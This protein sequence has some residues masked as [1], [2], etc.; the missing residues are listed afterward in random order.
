MNPPPMP[1]VFQGPGVGLRVGAP[2]GTRLGLPAGPRQNSI[3]LSRFFNNDVH[4]A[5]GTLPVEVTAPTPTTPVKPPNS[6]LREFNDLVQRLPPENHDLLQTIVE[7]LARATVHAKTTKMP[8]S[9]LLLVFCPSV[10]I[11][12]SVFKI[13]VENH[14]PIFDQA[15]LPPPSPSPS[16]HPSEGS[17]V[18]EGEGINAAN[19]TSQPTPSTETDYRHPRTPPPQLPRKEP[20]GLQLDLKPPPLPLVQATEVPNGAASPP[21]SAYLH[22]PGLGLEPNAG[23]MSPSPQPPQLVS[24]PLGPQTTSHAT[25]PSMSPSSTP[26]S[27]SPSLTSE[28]NATVPNPGLQ[29]FSSDPQPPKPIPV[30]YALQPAASQSSLHSHS[31]TVSIPSV[32]PSPSVTLPPAQQDL[33]APSQDL[34]DGPSAF[35]THQVQLKAS[36]DKPLPNPDSPVAPVA[37]EA[38]SPVSSPSPSVPSPTLED[39]Q[40]SGD[41]ADS[42]AKP[43]RRQYPRVVSMAP[44]LPEFE[45]LPPMTAS[46][47][48][49]IPSLSPP[50]P[51]PS[52]APLFALAPPNMNSKSM[53]TSTITPLKVKGRGSE[54][55]KLVS[56]RTGTSSSTS[57][58]LESSISRQ[59]PP[60]IS[61][62]DKEPVSVKGDALD[63]DMLEVSETLPLGSQLT[64]LM[65]A[66]EEDMVHVDDIQEKTSGTEPSGLPEQSRP[67]SAEPPKRID[68][69]PLETSPPVAESSTTRLDTFVFG[70]ST[71]TSPEAPIIAAALPTAPVFVPPIVDPVPEDIAMPKDEIG[72][73]SKVECESLPI[74]ELIS[75][76]MAEART[77]DHT[78]LQNHTPPQN[79]SINEVV[80]TVERQSASPSPLIDALPQREGALDTV[81]LAESQVVAPPRLAPPGEGR[82]SDDWAA[83]VL[84]AATTSP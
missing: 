29:D 34:S 64:P 25:P 62:S 61:P 50:P 67:S 52:L 38:P 68:S 3:A 35:S 70:P 27:S 46:F 54:P 28:L 18:Y 24:N 84:M 11:N 51:M 65:R 57:S 19:A 55:A 17:D 12:S 20:A 41:D 71:H 1:T 77:Q 39:D 69:L 2:L 9:N 13:M 5:P 60:G 14:E 37:P 74:G 40:N 8:L 80:D 23:M 44:A 7:L 66:M 79:L 63:E 4:I 31:S 72:T 47:A 30:P 56:S 73:S 33:P 21:Q 15:L 48:G 36:F 78:P 82:L 53:F 81:I 83:S 16:E 59:L 22:S 32:N 6:L 49:S 10:G 42:E 75:T 58:S 26:S 76:E 43:G 45:S